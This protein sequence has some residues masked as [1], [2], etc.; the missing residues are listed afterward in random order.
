MNIKNYNFSYDFSLKPGKL[1]TF[2]LCPMASMTEHLLIDHV[3][4]H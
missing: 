2:R 3:K 4:I 1:N